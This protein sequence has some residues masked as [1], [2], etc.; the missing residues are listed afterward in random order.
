MQC[1]LAE[2][3]DPLVRCINMAPGF[4]CDPCPSGYT[5]SGHAGLQGQGLEFARRNR[6][7]CYDID[8]CERN[9]GGCQENSRCINTDGSFYCGE[10]AAGFYGNQTIGCHNRPGL[11]PDGSF[12]DDN[13]ECVRLPGLNYY[14]CRVS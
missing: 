5:G 13:S 11:C 1:D 10:C 14:V 6:Q 9:N 8:E 12:C 7:R 3:C 4:R 2:P